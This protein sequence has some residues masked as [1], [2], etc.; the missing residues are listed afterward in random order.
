MIVPIAIVVAIVITE[1]EQALEVVVETTHDG[2]PSWSHR[3]RGENGPSANEERTSTGETIAA[4]MCQGLGL[5]VMM[6]VWTS[7]QD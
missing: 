3:A 2:R 6:L 7:Q 5:P 1:G 4:P